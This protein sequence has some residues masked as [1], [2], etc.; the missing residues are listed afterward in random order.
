LKY[1]LPVHAFLAA[2][3]ILL[4]G[5]LFSSAHL[6][7]APLALQSVTSENVTQEMLEALSSFI[8]LL[9]SLPHAPST[10]IGLI[11]KV[12]CLFVDV[13][14]ALIH[15]PLYPIELPP[16]LPMGAGF[17]RILIGRT[18]YQMTSIMHTAPPHDVVR[19]LQHCFRTSC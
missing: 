17:I 11:Q 14:V 6:R 9:T 3:P 19:V 8:R 18:H 5:P 2:G 10:W 13:R 16:D 12:E 4:V 7:L 1:N 15:Q